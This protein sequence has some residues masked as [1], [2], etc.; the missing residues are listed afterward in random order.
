MTKAEAA[1]GDTT[2]FDASAS[3]TGCSPVFDIAIP[4]AA[5]PQARLPLETVKTVKTVKTVQTV[6]TVKTVFFAS[7][8]PF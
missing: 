2:A 4:P 1:G 7:A 5:P 3:Y 6:K 8:P